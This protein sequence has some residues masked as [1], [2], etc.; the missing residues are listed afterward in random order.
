[1]DWLDAFLLT[2]FA[3][4]ILAIVCDTFRREPSEEEMFKRLIEIETRR[5]LSAT[6]KEHIQ[7]RINQEA[8]DRINAHRGL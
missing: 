7:N 4:G 6:A 3:C 2:I 1:M 5:R 8:T